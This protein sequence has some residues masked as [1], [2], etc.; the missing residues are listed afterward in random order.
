MV[1]FAFL[2]LLVCFAFLVSGVA[3]FF[4]SQELKEAMKERDGNGQAESAGDNRE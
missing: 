3:L 1:V 2:Y 4:K